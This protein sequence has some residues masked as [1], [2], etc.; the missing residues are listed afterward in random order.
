MKAGS[1]ASMRVHADEWPAPRTRKSGHDNGSG[2]SALGFRP[3]PPAA[4]ARLADADFD[5]VGSALRSRTITWGVALSNART[6]SSTMPSSSTVL[7]LR[8]VISAVNTH[9]DPLAAMRSA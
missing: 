5:S 2:L 7:P 3:P 6:A 9:F 8:Y 4:S 1:L